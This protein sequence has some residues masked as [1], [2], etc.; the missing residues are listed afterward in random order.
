MAPV[1]M[2]DS[3]TVDLIAIQLA[4]SR[5][6]NEAAKG[7]LRRV[8]ALLAHLMAIAV[9][10]LGRLPE[11]VRWWR[12][13]RRVADKAGDPYTS[14]WI[15]GHEVVRALYERR[16]LSAVLTLV[17]QAERHA[18]HTPATAMPTL[19][20]GKAQALAMRGQADD[21]EA[22][23]RQ[24]REV[25]A[26]LPSEVTGNR[27]SWFGWPEYRLRFTESFVHAELGQF[28]QAT[29]AQ[30]RALTIYPPMY[31]HGPAQIQLQRARC[32]VDC[33]DT[34]GGVRHAQDTL[35]GLPSTHRGLATVELGRK[36][37]AAVPGKERRLPA[38]AEF[39][40][41]LALAGNQLT[42]S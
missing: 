30:D 41:Y 29:E 23:L 8:G 37:L 27:E 21:A 9:G 5:E 31:I 10:G 12:T 3:L 6:N 22:A 36:A 19:L 15:R 16:P 26:G 40:E 32:L 14:T 1:D 18:V 35:A 28:E 20:A 11:A 24:L 7:E 33:G 39:A 42:R 17:E 38:V 4:I 34:T 2:L 13:A 25:F